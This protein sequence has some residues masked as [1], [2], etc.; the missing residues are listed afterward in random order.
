MRN[1]FNQVGNGVSHFDFHTLDLCEDVEMFHSPSIL[2]FLFL[3]LTYKCEDE[4][5]FCDF[6][7]L[8]GDV[9]M[10]LCPSSRKKVHPVQCKTKHSA[11]AKKIYSHS[12]RGKDKYIL[13]VAGKEDIL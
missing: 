5:T 10:F 8:C 6:L 13:I 3:L 9:E 11:V 4:T 7:A 1:T 12:L 2:I